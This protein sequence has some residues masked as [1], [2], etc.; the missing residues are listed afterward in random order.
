MSIFMKR[1][2]ARYTIRHL[3]AAILQLKLVCRSEIK[4]SPP[5]QVY[6]IFLKLLL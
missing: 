5:L 3:N 6:K 2:S 1:F 4:D